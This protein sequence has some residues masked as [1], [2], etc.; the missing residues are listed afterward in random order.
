[1]SMTTEQV[2]KIVANCVADL[3]FEGMICTEEDKE[4]MRR[5]ASGQTTAADEIAAIVAKYKKIS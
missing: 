2:E 3:A 5:V 1:M 4:R